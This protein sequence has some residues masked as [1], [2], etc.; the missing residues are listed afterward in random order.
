MKK[1]WYS[2]IRYRLL[3]EDEAPSPKDMSYNDLYNFISRVY[4]SKKNIVILKGL[5]EPTSIIE[6]KYYFN[7][8]SDAASRL[9]GTYQIIEDVFKVGQI[10]RPNYFVSGEVF[11]NNTLKFINTTS[12]AKRDPYEVYFSFIELLDIDQYKDIDIDYD[13][14]DELLPDTELTRFN[15]QGEALLNFLKT[16]ATTPDKYI[17]LINKY[18]AKLEDIAITD[19]SFHHPSYE[20]PIRASEIVGFNT[21]TKSSGAKALFIQTRHDIIKLYKYR[22]LQLNEIN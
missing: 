13:K 1:S 12:E 4:N 9:N 14:L 16:L 7:E 19:T 11:N 10:Y 5:D 8:D 2:D 17:F 6:S 21:S 20:Y 3:L 22:H 18:P 15:N